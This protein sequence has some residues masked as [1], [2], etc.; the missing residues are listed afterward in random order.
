MRILIISLLLSA[1]G[2]K[3][4][5]VLGVRSQGGEKS[6]VS[7]SSNQIGNV[8]R[9]SRSTD[10]G[11]DEIIVAREN[12]IIENVENID[13]YEVKILENDAKLTEKN[14]Q[15]PDEADDTIADPSADAPVMVIGAYL[16]SCEVVNQITQCMAQIDNGMTMGDIRVMTPTGD[17]IPIDRVN[18]LYMNEAESMVMIMVADPSVSE[19][20]VGQQLCQFRDGFSWDSEASSCIEIIPSTKEA[21]DLHSEYYWSEADMLCI[22]NT[23]E[24]GTTLAQIDTNARLYPG[25]ILSVSIDLGKNALVKYIDV[26]TDWWSKRPK[27]IRVFSAI[28]G[29]K[30]PLLQEM[31]VETRDDQLCGA[32]YQSQCTHPEAPVARLVVELPTLTRI[33]S[34]IV[35]ADGNLGGSFS[36]VFDLGVRN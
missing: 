33:S 17:L 21:C 26:Y 14:S 11:A 1:C 32:D 19:T 23:A 4:T 29:M 8:E 15:T 34:I 28:N 2:S 10:A 12:T 20:Q 7:D 27:N 3:D 25:D 5:Q 9:I 22:S 30:G 6:N 31:L 16:V 18:I 35:E 13:S 24:L 36:F